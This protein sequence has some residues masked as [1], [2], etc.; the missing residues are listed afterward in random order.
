M[1]LLGWL[2]GAL[3]L[4]LGALTGLNTE[5]AHF[6][7]ITS[8][9]PSAATIPVVLPAP[10]LLAPPSTSGSFSAAMRYQLALSVGFSPAEA[11]MAVAVSL[12]ENFAGDPNAVNHNGGGRGDDI[13]LWQIN[14][15]HAA[16][17]G[18]RQ[19]LF[20]PVV[21]A[22]VALALSRSGSGWLQWCT[23]PHGCGGLPGVPNFSSLLTQAQ[24]VAG[25]M[26]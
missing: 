7:P 18:G 2:I 10:V 24:A 21:N 8:S 25:G 19:N 1:R 22:R 20:D 16:M 23:V 13:G 9:Q 15:A 4:V 14:D 3:V 12:A 26:P 5:L 6:E 11:V 17:A